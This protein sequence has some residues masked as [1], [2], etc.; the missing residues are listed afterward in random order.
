MLD[1]IDDEDAMDF[2][3]GGTRLGLGEDGVLRVPKLEPLDISDNE[4]SRMYRARVLEGDLPIVH[5]PV[6]PWEPI[7]SDES[8]SGSDGFAF[9]G[10]SMSSWMMWTSSSKVWLVTWSTAFWKML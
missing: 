1:D 10:G 6:A 2:I 4:R 8:S 3:F 7:F 5:V 9:G